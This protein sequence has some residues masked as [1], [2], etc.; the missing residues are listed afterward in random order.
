MQ[1]LLKEINDIVHSWLPIS[2]IRWERELNS[3][4]I[5]EYFEDKKIIDSLFWDSF[6]AYELT[7]EQ[8]ELLFEF[9][10]DKSLVF[11]SKNFWLIKQSEQEQKWEVELLISDTPN[12]VDVVN[13]YR[14]WETS[15]ILTYKELKRIEKEFTELLKSS[16]LEVGKEVIDRVDQN[17]S[18]FKEFRVSNRVTYDFK[19]YSYAPYVE[20]VEVFD[21]AK[22]EVNE[23]EDIIKKATEMSMTNKTLVDDNWEIIP[24]VP[25]KDNR[26]LTYTPKKS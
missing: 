1:E 23:L 13:A 24:P 17:P 8:L 11:M 10:K 3:K 6:Y 12:I 22:K 21:K 4:L 5:K 2:Y 26:I 16:L 15:A 20:K 25:F 14:S 18:E 7:K 9:V 19:W